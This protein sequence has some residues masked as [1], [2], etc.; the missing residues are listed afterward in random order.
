LILNP[1]LP[2]LFSEGKPNFN[3]NS[4]WFSNKFGTA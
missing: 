2:I 1:L 4:E 3:A